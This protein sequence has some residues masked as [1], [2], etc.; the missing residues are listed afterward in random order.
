MI[1]NLTPRNVRWGL[2]YAAL[3]LV[4]AWLLLPFWQAFAWSLVLAAVTWPLYR[5]V[6]KLLREMPTL[7]AVVMTLLVIATIAL[8]LTFTFVAISH[9]AG[10]ALSALKSALAAPPPPPGW[11]ERFPPLVEAYHNA[12]TTLQSGIDVQQ[13]WM[14]SLLQPGTRVVAAAGKSVLQVL[15]ALFTVFF[16]YRNGERYRTQAKAVFTHLMGNQVLRLI[17]PTKE[18]LRAVFAGVI[19]AAAAQG[20]VAALGYAMVGLHAPV[21]LGVATA[22]AALIPFGGVLIWGASAIGL[23]ASGA[24]LKGGLLFAWGV[25]AVSNIDNLVRPLVISGTTRLPYLQVFFAFMGGLAT[26]GLIGLFIGPALLAVWM[27]LWHEW[28]EAGEQEVQEITELTA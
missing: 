12:I 14:L 3:T 23:I 21:L 6:R 5:R 28:V 11:L 22:I 1:S 9:E 7:S 15:F 16:F 4:S 26:F 2:C 17:G 27:V 8:P 25:L 19:L 24:L 13:G 18:T 10:P 20:L